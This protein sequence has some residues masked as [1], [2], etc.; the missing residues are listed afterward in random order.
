MGFCNKLNISMILSLLTLIGFLV[1]T[2]L[3]SFQYSFPYEE[4]MNEIKSQSSLTHDQENTIIQL[5][6]ENKKKT[7]KVVDISKG[8]FALV[9]IELAGTVAV[10]IGFVACSKLLTKKILLGIIGFFILLTVCYFGCFISCFHRT[11]NAKK[12]A[13]TIK[14]IISAHYIDKFYDDIKKSKKDSL[15][16]LILSIIH[17][18]KLPVLFILLFL[19]IYKSP[20]DDIKGDG[21]QNVREVEAVGRTNPKE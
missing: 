2:S 15:Y 21:E 7:D 6:V 1:N 3:I 4:S 13:D 12:N 10:I 11:K 8:C 5:M 17:I 9:V 16:N 14:D 19:G 18:I 20:T